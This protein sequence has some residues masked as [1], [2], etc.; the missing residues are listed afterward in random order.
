MQSESGPS[1]RVFFICLTI[2]WLLS[3]SLSYSQEPD[4]ASGKAD[5]NLRDKLENM[6]ENYDESIDYSDLTD[7]LEYLRENPL[8]L[9]F[10]TLADLDKLYFLNEMQKF[11]LLA[12]RENFGY[13]VTIYEL[14]AV[15]GLDAETLAKIL[16]YV[17]VTGEK[18]KKKITPKDVAKYGRNE[19]V[20]RYQRIIEEQKGYSPIDDSAYFENP[21]SR[22]LGSPDKMFLKYKFHY[23]DRIR[24]GFLAEKDAGEVLLKSSVNDSLQKL[25]G[26]KLRNGFDFY[27]FHLNLHEFGIL[28]SLSL[29]DYQLSFGQGLTLWSGLAFGRSSEA[30]DVKKFGRGIRPSTSANEY[31]FFRGAAATLNYKNIDLTAFYSGRSIDARLSE[32]D[33]LDAETSYIQSLQETGLHRT[34]SE[35]SNKS[36]IRTRV[37]GGNLSWYG[38]WFRVGFTSFYSGLSKNLLAADLPY[39]QFEFSGTE[40]F[41]AGLDYTFLINRINLFG[42][43]SQSRNGGI[44]QLHGL[45]ANFHSD[46]TLTVLYRNYQKD[47]Q[48]FYSN[49]FAVGSEN[50]NEQGIYAGLSIRLPKSLSLHAWV[51]SYRFPWLKY[52]VDAPS[53]GTDCLVRIQYNFTDSS[54]F[55]FQFR[56]KNR[57]INSDAAESGTTALASTLKNYFRFQLQYNIS[58]AISLKNILEYVLAREGNYYKG[59]GYL[60]CQDIAWKNP[61][62]RTSLAFRYALFDTDSYEERIYAY[63]NDLL[64][65]FSVTAYYFK[66]TRVYFLFHYKLTSSLE[67]WLRL[68][69]TSYSNLQSVGTAL[70]QIPSNHKTEIKAQL[71]LKF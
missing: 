64:Y 60:A 30:T 27:S 68:S 51:D 3:I 63:E 34:P 35:L 13:Y 2:S 29:G 58:P 67:F 24:F 59:T 50:S 69:R 9:N 52:R 11:N 42:E 21:D 5:A 55:F 66:G 19:C 45:T 17:C 48:N 33:S 23:F 37:I 54:F 39:N 36:S 15:E 18:P 14:Q 56:Q 46:I 71:R 20:V 61:S 1:V 44:A 65:A 25:A 26:S 57:Q 38:N 31:L 53:R 62:G 16:P 47:Y 10:V 4:T 40:N 12:Y 22:Y 70:D 49:A 8:N 43:V 32:P 41:N 28:K 7:E 6:A